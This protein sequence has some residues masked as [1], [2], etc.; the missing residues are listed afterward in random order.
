MGPATWG[1]FYIEM[2]GVPPSHKFHCK[3]LPVFTDS[4]SAKSMELYIEQYNL[5]RLLK[6]AL[7]NGLVRFTRL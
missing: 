2:Y 7:E 3:H 5:S 1:I 6:T 4:F